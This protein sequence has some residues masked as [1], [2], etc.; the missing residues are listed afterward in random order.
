MAAAAIALLVPAAAACGSDP[1][2]Q[3]PVASVDF[4][5]RLVVTVGDTSATADG[6]GRVGAV[7]GGAGGAAWSV[8][9][10]SVVELDM[11]AAEPRQVEISVTPTATADD[12]ETS[13]P[14]A[15]AGTMQPG[16]STVLA[17]SALGVYRITATA[18]DGRT[19]DLAVEVVP[20]SAT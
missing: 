4:E 14:W 13:A 11:R 2:A 10:G 3:P 6:T 18:P 8:P 9:S 7:E 5:P 16:E 17:L 19:T 20:R 12:P 15:D 1:D